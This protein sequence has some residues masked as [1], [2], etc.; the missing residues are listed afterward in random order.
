MLSIYIT[1]LSSLNG[2]RVTNERLIA[3]EMA[4]T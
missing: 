1:T 2:Y 3:I 4:S